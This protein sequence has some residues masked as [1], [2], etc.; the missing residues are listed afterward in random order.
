MAMHGLFTAAAGWRVEEHRATEQGAVLVLPIRLRIRGLTRRGLSIPPPPPLRGGDRC[1]DAYYRAHGRAHRRRRGPVASGLHPYFR[2]PGVER[3]GWRLEAPVERRLRLDPRQL[4]PASASRPRSSP[5]RSAAAPST[6]PSRLRSAAP[7]R[8]HRRRPASSLRSSRVIRTPGLAP[9]GARDRD[10]ADDRGHG[11]PRHRRRAALRQPARRLQRAFSVTVVEELTVRVAVVG[12]VEWIEFA[13]VDRLPAAGEIVHATECWQEPPGAGRVAAVQLAQ[14]RRGCPSSPRSP[15]TR[16]PP[17]Q[18]RGWRRWA[19]VEAV[20]GPRPQRRG[21][22]HVDA[23]GERTITVIGERLGPAAADPLPWDE[24]ADADAV[25]LTAGDAGPRSGRPGGRKLVATARALTALAG[26]GVELD[27]LV[28]SA[29][30]PGERYETGRLDPPPR[31]SSARRARPEA[32]PRRGGDGSSWKAAPL[33]GP[34]VDA[35]GCGRQLRR[36]AHLRARHGHDRGGPAPR[37][38]L[39]RSQHR[40]ARPLRGPAARATAAS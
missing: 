6:T 38:P 34:A 30:D 27:A 12:H 29:R 13:R 20:F 36:R 32:S 24:L 4:P 40:R 14:A 23:A 37:R 28:A 9:A 19:R 3:S 5:A 17:R 25:Y 22:V 8:P 31:S 16:W 10:R 26:A 2:L 15:T 35:Y 21:F 39:R 18:G 11:C 7:L 33:P 1:A